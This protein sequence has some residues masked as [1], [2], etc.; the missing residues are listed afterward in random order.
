M[1]AA[2][3]TR[4]ALSQPGPSCRYERTDAATAGEIDWG[5]SLSLGGLS[6]YWTGAVPRFAPDDFTEGAR[7]RRAVR[8]A[9]RATT[10]WSPTTTPPSAS[11]TSRPV[12]TRSPA[13]RRTSC[14][15]RT[16]LPADWQRDRSTRRTG[17]AT[18]SASCR[19]PR[20][21][22]GWSPVGHG[23]R[24]LPLRRRAAARRRRVRA[25]RRG[26]RRQRCDG[27]RPQAAST[28]SSTS[29]VRDGPAADDRRARAVVVAAGCDRLDRAAAALPVGR[30]PRRA[31]QHRRR[32]RPLPPRPP[33]EW[34]PAQIDRPLRALAHPIYI[35]RDP[36]DERPAAAGDVADD[37]A[38]AAA[39]TAQDLLPRPAPGRSACRSSARW[40]RHGPV[41]VS[42]RRGDATTRPPTAD[43]RI[44]LRYDDAPSPTSRRPENACGTSSPTPGHRRR[45][46]RD[47]ST[48]CDP[49]RRCTTAARCGCTT[50]PSS[51][52]STAWNRLHEV[53]NVAVVDS[54]AFTTGPEK[55]PTLTAMALASRAADRLGTDLRDGT[56]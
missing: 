44:T 55:N 8:V 28:R 9:G 45:P 2:G 31:R 11:S 7:R 47:R 50:D 38:V 21:A 36:S 10:T 35:A 14:A 56:V 39:R 53:P 34:W 1:R 41:G 40:C 16:R 20:G 12:A 51:G 43:R 42:H 18:A 37:R 25:D 17:T 54:S 46:S 15:T 32:D 26:A 5:S 49:G 3:N 6:N 19:W 48:S 52:C 13:S 30:L 29:I 27:R 24:Q 4:G 22:R 23:V 33:R